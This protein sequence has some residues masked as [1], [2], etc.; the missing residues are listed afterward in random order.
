MAD[1][2]GAPA[3]WKYDR[4]PP[5]ETSLQDAILNNFNFD[6]LYDFVFNPEKVKGQPYKPLRVPT[7]KPAG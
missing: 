7:P 4:L 1:P 6:Y 3:D 2:L 5:P